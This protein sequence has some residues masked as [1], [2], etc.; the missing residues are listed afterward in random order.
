MAIT[1]SG[2]A[3]CAWARLGSTGKVI[4]AS[5]RAVNEEV[6]CVVDNGKQCLDQIKASATRSNFRMHRRSLYLR[7]FV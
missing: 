1:V 2:H 5:G 3:R 4:K 6:A 7:R